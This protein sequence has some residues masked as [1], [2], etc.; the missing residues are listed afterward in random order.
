MGKMGEGKEKIQA[1]GYR[2]N[3]SHG[4]KRHSTKNIVSGT[5]IVSY[6]ERWELL[7]Q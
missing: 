7:L 2:V 4:N 1:S 5:G 6:G 3:M